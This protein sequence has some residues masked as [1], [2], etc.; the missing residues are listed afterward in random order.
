MAKHIL[1]IFSI[2]VLIYG[3]ASAQTV[4]TGMSI[5]K[6][7]IGNDGS[8]AIWTDKSSSD[9]GTANT[10]YITAPS[11]TS[12]KLHRMLIVLLA[13]KLADK[14]ISTTTYADN[15]REFAGPTPIL[16][17]ISIE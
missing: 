16:A 2:F 11:E 4:V 10:V 5:E 15:C 1:L 9:C 6:I 8:I 14:T 13:A 12:D 17:N 3:S 7:E